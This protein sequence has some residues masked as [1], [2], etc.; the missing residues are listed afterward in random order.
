MPPAVDVGVGPV[1]LLAIFVG[2]DEPELGEQ[3]D[4]NSVERNPAWSR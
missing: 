1:E 3:A 2:S 4:Q